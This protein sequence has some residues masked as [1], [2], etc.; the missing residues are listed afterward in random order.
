MIEKQKIEGMYG[1]DTELSLKETVSFFSTKVVLLLGWAMNLST[2][3]DAYDTDCVKAALTSLGGGS[4]HLQ[5]SSAF[6]IIGKPTL[7]KLDITP[8]W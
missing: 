3:Y 1:K 8:A 6:L 7:L 4:T 5:T 2:S